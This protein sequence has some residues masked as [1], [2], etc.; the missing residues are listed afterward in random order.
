MSSRF[1][2]VLRGIRPSD[3][4]LA[5]ALAALGGWLMVENVRFPDSEVAAALADGDLA[6]RMTS[7][8]WAMLPVFLL[9]PL[10]VLWWRRSIVAVTGFALAV[11]VVH[12]LAFG[13]V[14]RCGAGLPL[15]F[16]LA[17]LGAVALD[18]A[19]ASV[20]LG[21]T[22]LLT[23]A[24]LVVDATTGPGPIVL[25]VPIVLIVFAIGRAVRQRTTM[26]AELRAR[27]AELRQLR[28]DRAALEVV[29]DRV[30]L[31]RE[32]DGLLEQRLAELAT[33]AESGPDLDPARAK[34]L[35]ASIETASRATLDGMRDIVGLLRGGDVALAPAPTVAHLEAMLARHTRADS[36]L[37]VSGDPR[38][39]PA[40]V[41]LS[42]YRIVE[43][44]VDVLADSPGSRIEV[45]VRFEPATLE[46]RVHGPVARSADVRAA[47]TR[48][49]ERATFLGGTL[50]VRLSRG[51]ADAV[52]QIPLTG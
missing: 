12:D 1:N 5:G 29:G 51:L 19:Q 30:R 50:S 52:A 35:F 49:R 48:A 33:A 39:L 38:S 11:L 18:R 13:W 8:A 31:S 10:A 9:A 28:D 15:T 21:L 6:H 32:L 44:L 17:Y 23:A 34:E 45:G 22:L 46:I 14:T 47:A 4:I 41:E 36:R 16:V 40:T 7:H 24:V 26:S 3:G 42:A 20:V 37:T 2:E 25:A 43:H 27:T